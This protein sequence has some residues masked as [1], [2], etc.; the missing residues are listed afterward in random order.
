M[1]NQKLYIHKWKYTDDGQEYISEQ[2]LTYGSIEDAINSYYQ[3]RQDGFNKYIYTL[4]INERSGTVETLAIDEIIKERAQ[5][6]QGSIERISYYSKADYHD[7]Q[8]K[9]GRV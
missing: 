4:K 1:K 6:E 2:T 8:R 9:E 5:S 3:E 7:D